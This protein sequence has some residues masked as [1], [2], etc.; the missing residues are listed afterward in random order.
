MNRGALIRSALRLE[1]LTAGW[2]VIEA[3]VA[4]GA[5]VV[6][7]SLTLLAFG[8]D[9]L[10]ELISAGVLLW[11]LKVELVEGEEFS[12]KAERAASRIGAVLL[13]SLALYVVISAIWGLWHGTGQETSLVGMLVAAA[14]IPVMVFLAKRKSWLSKAIGS[15]ALRADAAESITCA[16]LSGA[17]LIGLGA[18]LLLG[19]WWVDSVTALVLVPFLLREAREAW[20]EDECDEE[21]ESRRRVE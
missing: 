3:A 9:S 6:A 11:R 7:S 21:G 15:S 13:G 10:I 2:M 20:E 19:A 8:I 14:A 4:I 1:W 12:E 5:A 17:V 16:Y 18:Q